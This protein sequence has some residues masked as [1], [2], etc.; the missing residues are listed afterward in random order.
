MAA[1]L[2][3]SGVGEET[4]K[5]R[6]EGL[7]AS[8]GQARPP[9]GGGEWPHND[10]VVPQ[11]LGADLAGT[12]GQLFPRPHPLPPAPHLPLAIS[13]WLERQV[14]WSRRSLTLVQSGAV[15]AASSSSSV[16]C[17]CATWN[18]GLT[19]QTGLG[20]ARFN[21]F[22][23]CGLSVYLLYSVGGRGREARV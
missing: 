11:A 7:C 3:P 12:E 14:V 2:V 15:S 19:V 17:H 20:D 10:S 23:S 5:H 21:R 13:G 9:L 18:T 4:P 16:G 6:C 8:V 22:L 1:S